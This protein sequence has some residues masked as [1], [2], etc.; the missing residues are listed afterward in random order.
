M[1]TKI[2]DWIIDLQGGPY[3]LNDCAKLF[4]SGTEIRVEREQAVNSIPRYYLH[5]SELKGLPDTQ[6]HAV[7][8]KLIAKLN[9]AVKLQGGAGSLMMGLPV[10]IRADG[11]RIPMKVVT[12]VSSMP[13]ESLADAASTHSVPVENLTS[14][15]STSS[16]LTEALSSFARKVFQKYW[17]A[18][19]WYLFFIIVGWFCSYLL[20]GWPSV[21]AAIILNIITFVIGLYA[22]T[23]TYEIVTEIRPVRFRKWLFYM[24]DDLRRLI[25]G[26]H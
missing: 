17:P 8:A 24:L 25:W 15:A 20:S 18:L 4:E 19:C 5:S 7:A 12:A 11:S 1:D 21:G 14:V 23:T 26:G 6:I 22:I 3:D 13:N 2:I 16:T 9:E 10:T